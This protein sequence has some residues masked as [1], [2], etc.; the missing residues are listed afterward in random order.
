MMTK[1]EIKTITY[2]VVVDDFMVDVVET[3]YGFECYIYRMK[4]KIKQF[5]FGLPL[6][7][8]NDFLELVENNLPFYMEDYDT[9]EMEDDD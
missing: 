9:M 7:Y 5:M 2:K 3:D 8:I 6:K 1:T 4:Y